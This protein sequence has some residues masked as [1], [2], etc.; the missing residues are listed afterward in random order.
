MFSFY[1]WGPQ[2]NPKN[3]G[4]AGTQRVEGGREVLE[5]PVWEYDVRD[6]L[7]GSYAL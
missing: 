2:I 7:L 4:R 5:A 3:M 6:S 1:K